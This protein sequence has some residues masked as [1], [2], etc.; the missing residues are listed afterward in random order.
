[1]P[2][3]KVI[4]LAVKAEVLDQIRSRCRLTCN[5][6]PDGPKMQRMIAGAFANGN[7][8]TELLDSLSRLIELPKYHID[9]SIHLRS[10]RAETQEAASSSHVRA[11]VVVAI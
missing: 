10:R 1:M 8:G 5:T 3:Y 2:G 7:R 4:D 9:R 6:G 11:K